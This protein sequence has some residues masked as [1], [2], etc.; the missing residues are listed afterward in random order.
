[1]FYKLL[2]QF[3]MNL[4]KPHCLTANVLRNMQTIPT[5]TFLVTFVPQSFTLLLLSV[6]HA[7]IPAS[8]AAF[9]SSSILAGD[10]S[11]VTK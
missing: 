8:R 3:L 4:A 7:L 11:K 9:H 6:K 2:L 1:M 10:K 5:K